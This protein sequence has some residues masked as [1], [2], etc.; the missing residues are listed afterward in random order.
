[1]TTKH[2]VENIILDLDSTLIHAVEPDNLPSNWEKNT[3]GLVRVNM[4][5]V[6]TVFERP[7][8]QEFLDYIFSRYNV[9]V[10]TAASKDYALFIIKNI[11]LKDPNRKLDFIFYNYHC[12]YSDKHHKCSKDLSLIPKIF[13]DYSPQHTIIIDDYDDV[14]K[15][16]FNAIPAIPFDIN[17]SNVSKDTFLLNL[18]NDLKSSNN[19]H[20]ILPKY[21]K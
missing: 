15:D 21:R 1:M 14:Y 17:N 9:S 7:Y 3:R 19:I 16:Q 13:K 6:Y 18:M 20:S 12:K 4:D 5:D 2:K 8:L 11:V 10:W